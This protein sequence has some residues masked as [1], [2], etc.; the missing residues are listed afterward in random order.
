[1]DA[2]WRNTR[3]C[4]RVTR[5]KRVGINVGGWGWMALVK[6]K[7]PPVVSRRNTRPRKKHSRS[8]YRWPTGYLP[9][10]E[11]ATY[12]VQSL[13]SCLSLD[14]WQHLP[15]N[16]ILFFFCE[17]IFVPWLFPRIIN[18]ILIRRKDE[19]VWTWQRARFFTGK[20]HGHTLL[21]SMC[22]DIIG[23]LYK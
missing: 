20:D 15:S 16:T 12:R 23:F 6:R 4:V 10:R 17:E 11:Q 9:T 2:Q 7:G 8:A 5:L 22:Y 21:T 13:A 14:P 3:G 18:C 1:M 19:C